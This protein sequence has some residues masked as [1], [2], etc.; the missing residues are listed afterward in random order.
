MR[1]RSGVFSAPRDGNA[2]TSEGHQL[3]APDDPAARDL[4][5]ADCYNARDLGGY[6]TADRRT[7]RWQALIRADNLVRLTPAGQAALRAYGVRTILDL[8]LAYE[9][10]IDP[11]PFAATSGPPGEPRYVNRPLHDAATFAA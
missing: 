3:M 4:T 11:N 5:W 2:K 7:T 1:T 6:P 8:R 10:E 9:L